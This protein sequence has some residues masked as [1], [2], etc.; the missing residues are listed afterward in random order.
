MGCFCLANASA[1]IF[2]KILQK[3]LPIVKG[4]KEISAAVVE[5]TLK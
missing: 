1:K 5:G 2:L 3:V 4:F